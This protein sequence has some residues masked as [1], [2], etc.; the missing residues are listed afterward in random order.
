M[1]YTTPPDF[2][3]FDVLTAAQMDILSNNDISFNNGSGIDN[4]KILPNHL[5]ASAST[6]NNW[7]WDTFTP[8]WTSSGSAPSIGNG[9]FTGQYLKVGKIV[10]VQFSFVGGSSTTW[11][12]GTYYIN[13]PVTP[14]S[15]YNTLVG[16]WC[17]SGYVEDLS[18]QAFTVNG[19]RTQ[20]LTKFRV[21]MYAP[22][23]SVVLQWG[24][25]SPFTWSTGDLW[26]ASGFYEAA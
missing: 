9:T 25:T 1:A 12:T 2:T 21:T 19:S 17:L 10:F 8:T 23:G 16:G 6:A 18:L 3:P 11:G 5:F 13:Y 4:G 15:K 20:D 14:A 22:E 24:H 26:M 7:S